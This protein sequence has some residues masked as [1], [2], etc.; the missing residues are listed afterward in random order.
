MLVVCIKC[1]F[2]Q[3]YIVCLRITCETPNFQ[4]VPIGIHMCHPP[5]M[6]IC[7]HNSSRTDCGV[8][9]SSRLQNW[10]ES[11]FYYCPTAQPCYSWQ[12]PTLSPLDSHGSVFP[13]LIRYTSVRRCLRLAFLPK[14]VWK[15]NSNRLTND[16]FICRNSPA[17]SRRTP[18]PQR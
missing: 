13:Q 17:F 12:I 16:E 9:N 11:A 6:Q 18:N 8:E 14:T 5:T 4:F 2:L 3:S 1:L 15:V 10:S 7:S